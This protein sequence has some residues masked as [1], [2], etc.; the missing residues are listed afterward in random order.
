MAR[1]LTFRRRFSA[2]TSRHNG[3]PSLPHGHA[4]EVEIEVE[5]DDWSVYTSLDD[6]VEELDGKP[7]EKMVVGGSSDLWDLPT[8]I[9]ERLLARHP[10]IVRVSVTEQPENVT[11]SVRREVRQR[12]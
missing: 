7:L 2:G 11:A 4:Y 9:M 5:R 6:L 12:V 3:E 1:S 10:A 8:W